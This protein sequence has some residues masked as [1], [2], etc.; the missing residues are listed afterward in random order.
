MLAHREAI[1]IST[2]LV[3]KLS[4]TSNHLKQFSGFLLRLGAQMR[5][6][7]VA[8]LLLVG[9]FGVTAAR[10][11]NNCTGA[12]YYDAYSDT[13]IA[14]PTG[15]EYNK[16]SGKTDI[17]Q[18]QIH[19]DGGTYVSTYT[20]LEYIESTGTQW[21]DTGV[22][23]TAGVTSMEITLQ[24]TNVLSGQSGVVIGSN[25]NY[26][27]FKIG[28]NASGT[29]FLCQSGGE[30]SEALFGEPDTLK[31]TFILDKAHATCA[32]DGIVSNLN[33]N[34][35]ATDIMEH[36]YVGA[37]NTVIN[38]REPVTH[39]SSAKYYRFK[40]V[41]GNT[42]FRD[43][44][45]ARRNSD[46]A[47][48]MY[49][50]VSGQFFTNAGT[51]EFIAGPVIV[52]CIN[53]GT[54]YWAPSSTV[55]YGDIGM[56]NSCP[57][58]TYSDIENG[59]SVA[60]CKSCTGA[61]YNSKTAA[62]SCIACPRGYDYNNDSGKMDVSQCQIHCVGGTYVESAS[63]HVV[64]NGYT[65]LEYLES[66]GTQWID[67]EYVTRTTNIR[68]EIRVGVS[69]TFASSANVD[70]LGNQG[71]SGKYK[72]SLGWANEFKLYIGS[73][74]SGP[75]QAFEANS[76]HDLVYEFG[77]NRTRSLTI[78]GATPIS[79]TYNASYTPIS[80]A[81]L[82]LFTGR[83]AKT[84]SFKNGRIYYF[85]LYADGEL[86]RDMVPAR[87]DSDGVVGM[88]DIVTGRLFT[89]AGTGTFITGSDN[90][91]KCV[92]V[93]AGYYAPASTVNYGDTGTR[94][95]CP[96]GSTTVGYGHGADTANDC[97][98]IMR[99]GDY[100]VYGRR[101]QVTV[102]SLNIN[103]PDER[104]Y[105]ISLSPDNHSLSRL[106]LSFNGVKYTAYDDSLFYGERDFDTDA[107]IVQ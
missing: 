1:R 73:R 2:Q 34:A 102:P 9:V 40:F 47:I 106:H 62:A 71:D 80:P 23:P 39:P 69:K 97:A 18:C 78:D 77:D 65:Q 49:D 24:Y 52:G 41:N 59:A 94:T 83:D 3:Y 58:G 44:V 72:Y 8:I 57:A 75:T 7:F 89:N 13:C 21:I 90:I 19:C 5:R 48:G 70:I 51:G 103:I 101:D 29:N 35:N 84:A 14:C 42:L 6:I 95:A 100:V 81:S 32:M 60:A 33:S 91:G 79:G 87:R 98:R 28:I 36:I 107:Q 93:S 105:Y 92:N 99:I 31:H 11:Q 85:K 12:T 45:P 38:G 53:V 55:N 25:P 63:L 26:H 27:S 16:D 30:G 104:T 4:L 68:G 22:G 67:T 74:L 43:M 96:V 50:T 88:Y 86:V 64:P 82:A 10:A 37:Q 56:R 76:V 54:G 61:T 15:Y 66:T 20:Q 46:G 17:S